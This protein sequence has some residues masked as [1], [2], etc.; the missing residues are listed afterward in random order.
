MKKYVSP[1]I[2]LTELYGCDIITSSQTES[3]PSAG[4][5]S[6]VIDLYIEW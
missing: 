2:T 4:T 5:E 3:D 6:P 1:E